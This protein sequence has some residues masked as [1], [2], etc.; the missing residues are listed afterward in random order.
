MQG[1]KISNKNM[2]FLS[3]L[4]KKTTLMEEEKLAYTLWG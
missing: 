2:L 4:E 3:S 1:I